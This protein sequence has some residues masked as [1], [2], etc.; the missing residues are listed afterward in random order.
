MCSIVDKCGP[1]R[2]HSPWHPVHAVAGDRP[3]PCTF[4]GHRGVLVGLGL[5]CTN[6]LFP[7]KTHTYTT[8]LVDAQLAGALGL[9]TEYI[10]RLT[11]QS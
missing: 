10:S 11:S 8:S 5:E 6:E 9:R 3:D 7:A 2:R 4:S 1:T